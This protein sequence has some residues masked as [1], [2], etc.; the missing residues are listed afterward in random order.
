MRLSAA[1]G[2]TESGSIMKMP[3]GDPSVE[4]SDVKAPE[5]WEWIMMPDECK[6]RWDDQGDGTHELQ[7]LVGAPPAHSYLCDD[8]DLGTRIAP[9][10]N[11]L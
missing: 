6:V 5:D 7:L 11:P 8:D 4:S 3:F 9:H 2:A 10:I 1:Y